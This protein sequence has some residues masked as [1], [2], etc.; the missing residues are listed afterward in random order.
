M[1]GGLRKWVKEGR[2]TFKGPY[3]DGE[4]LESD[5]DFSYS[6]VDASKAFT[7]INEVHKVAYAIVQ[8]S[9]W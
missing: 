9:D 6:V 5:G 1:S 2:E 7:E 8:G 3:S 4:G